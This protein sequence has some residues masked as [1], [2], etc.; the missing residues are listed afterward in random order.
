M[1]QVITKLIED[2]L[3]ASSAISQTILEIRAGIANTLTITTAISADVLTNGIWSYVWR[4]GVTDHVSEIS[5]T[6]TAPAAASSTYTTPS[7]PATTWS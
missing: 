2:A 5:T 6:Y 3:T 4:G 1:V 7:T